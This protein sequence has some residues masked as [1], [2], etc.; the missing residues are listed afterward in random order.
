MSVREKEEKERK[1]REGKSATVNVQKNKGDCN[2]KKRK[3]KE[4]RLG[5]NHA[6]TRQSAT[7]SNTSYIYTQSCIM[8]I[9]TNSVCTESMIY[10]GPTVRVNSNKKTV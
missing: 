5:K 3:R 2:K 8:D 6:R 9:I 10:G 7:G 1:D 4:S